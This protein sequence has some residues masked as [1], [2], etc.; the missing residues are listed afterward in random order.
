MNLNDFTLCQMDPK[1]QNRKQIKNC[2]WK[3]VHFLIKNKFIFNYKKKQIYALCLLA[4]CLMLVFYMYALK[5]FATWP[6][7]KEVPVKQWNNNSP[8]VGLERV[9]GVQIFLFEPCGPGPSIGLV[10]GSLWLDRLLFL[11]WDNSQVYF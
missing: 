5:C 9:K 3:R 11:L 8:R 4:I 6:D 1:C 7:H 10:D 2:V